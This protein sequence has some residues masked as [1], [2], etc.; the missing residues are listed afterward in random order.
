MDSRRPGRR[1]S[2]F[3]RRSIAFTYYYYLPARKISKG[4]SRDVCAQGTQ[5][6]LYCFVLLSV[7]N[8]DRVFSVH[9][10]S[11][12]KLFD[13]RRIRCPTEIVRRGDRFEYSEMFD[14][15]TRRLLN[16]FRKIYFRQTI[17]HSNSQPSL[18][19]P[20]QFFSRDIP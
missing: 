20:A 12:K 3:S 9:F 8:A 14:P 5:S 4:F 19:V 11:K 2:A 18:C 6:D 1:T 15:V 7:V 16:F 13:L 10:E 17:F